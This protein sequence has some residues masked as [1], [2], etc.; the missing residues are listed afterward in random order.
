[1]VEIEAK[2]DKVRGA[3]GHT[4]GPGLLSLPPARPWPSSPTATSVS[5]S[6]RVHSTWACPSPACHTRTGVY[7]PHTHR[8]SSRQA[9]QGGGPWRGVGAAAR[10]LCLRVPGL[11]AKGTGRAGR[12]AQA[13]KPEGG[14]RG[15]SP[16]PLTGWS[17]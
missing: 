14:R 15:G 9:K 6:V 5:A 2:L 11:G 13:S 17:C 16:E 12:R 3:W 10:G 4:E 1:M 8:V 7:M